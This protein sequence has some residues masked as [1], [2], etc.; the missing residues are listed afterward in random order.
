LRQEVQGIPDRR[1]IDYFRR[2]GHDNADEGCYGEADGDCKELRPQ[3]VLGLA[4]ETRKIGVVDNKSGKV[5]DTGHDTRN[6]APRKGGSTGSSGL[7]DDRT[8]AF[9]TNDRPNEIRYASTRDKVGLDGKEVTDL[10][11][12]EPDGRKRSG[13]EEEE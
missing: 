7:V 1:A 12:W 10:V 5:G 9:G 6:A 8:D 11:D 13:P 3:R 2:G 4:C